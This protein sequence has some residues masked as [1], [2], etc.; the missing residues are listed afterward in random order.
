MRIACI[1][2]LHGDISF[3]IEESDILF[4]AGDI[5]P[6]YNNPFMS[7]P[8]QVKFLSN[9]FKNWLED[10]PIKEIVAIAGNHDW[11]FQYKHINKIPKLLWHYLEDEEIIINDMK[12]YGSPWQPYF[13]DW[14]FNA[15]DRELEHYWN[16]IPNDVDIL[17]LH[18]PP[19]G[20][21]DDIHSIKKDSHIGCKILRKR[22]FD[23]KPKYVIFGHAH[24]EYGIEK[25]DGITFINAS[26]CNGR[27]KLTKK[28]IYLNV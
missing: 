10:Q 22:I 28:P 2:D 23:I 24:E 15:N 16:N 14:A 3:G 18:S 25:I 8:G 11:I 17:L 19:Y 7:F 13:N 12:I 1:S 6:A 9:K 26:L 21:L 20:I 27:N 5:C 4:I